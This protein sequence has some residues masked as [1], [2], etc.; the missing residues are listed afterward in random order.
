MI[1]TTQHNIGYTQDHIGRD[2]QRMMDSSLEQGHSRD[3]TPLMHYNILAR[4][5]EEGNLSTKQCDTKWTINE[6]LVRRGLRCEISTTVEGAHQRNASLGN[7]LGCRATSRLWNSCRWMHKLL[8]GYLTNRASQLVTLSV[9]MEKE[10]EK[11]CD[12]S[13]FVF[14]QRHLY[15]GKHWTAL[16]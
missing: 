12:C 1:Q 6:Y 16:W 14:A 7:R 11:R 9:I 3:N 10:R 8:V 2:W 13:L 5:H 15:S 4:D